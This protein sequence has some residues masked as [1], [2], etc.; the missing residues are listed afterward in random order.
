MIFLGRG[1]LALA[2]LE[3]LLDSGIEISF[4][5]SG[6]HFKQAIGSEMDFQKIAEANDIP[7]AKIGSTVSPELQKFFGE[8]SCSLGMAISWPWLLP[9]SLLSR[10]TWGFLNIHAGLLPEYRGNACSN[11]AILNDEPKLGYTI[12]IMDSNL[13]SG[14][15]LEHRWFANDGKCR[16][17]EVIAFMNSDGP[18]RLVKIAKR[19]SRGEA[20]RGIP[21]EHALAIY[22]FPRIPSDGE[23]DWGWDAS[24]VFRLYRSL[25]APY[26]NPYTSLNGTHLEVLEMETVPGDTEWF[27]AEP[28]Q[29]LRTPPSGGVEVACGN[30][31]VVIR[32]VKRPGGAALA[33]ESLV[34]SVRDRFGDQQCNL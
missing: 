4:I 32:A 31:S 13:D 30:G 7:F 15:I 29:V 5:G 6:A 12:H 18:V 34:N 23:I 33:P 3:G 21:Q 28:G 9:E 14:P 2:T 8:V 1:E 26:P 16:V 25:G 22:R 19:A 10:A 20:I 11:W 27:Q 24:S 17:G